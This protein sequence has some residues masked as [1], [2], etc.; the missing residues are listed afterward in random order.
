MKIIARVLRKLMGTPPETKESPEENQI[1]VFR[2]MGMEGASNTL[3]NNMPLLKAQLNS[4]DDGRITL[5]DIRQCFKPLYAE[6]DG[7]LSGV[8][9]RMM[10]TAGDCKVDIT[11]HP[12]AQA[13]YRDGWRSTIK[14]MEEAFNFMFLMGQTNPRMTNAMKVSMENLYNKLDSVLPE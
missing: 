4:V 11:I 9:S 3:L 6:C 14:V 1:L 8:V 12:M 2:K 10:T 13:A 7:T 5:E